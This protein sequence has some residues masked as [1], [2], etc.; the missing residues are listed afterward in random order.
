M[1]ELQQF[2][3]MRS[4]HKAHKKKGRKLNE[5]ECEVHEELLTQLQAQVLNKKNSS[6]L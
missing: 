1:H 6:A 5:Q 4:T 2:D 3:R